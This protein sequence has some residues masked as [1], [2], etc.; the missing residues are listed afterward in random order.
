MQNIGALEGLIQEIYSRF[1]LENAKA[2]LNQ[3]VIH[4]CSHH[5]F[6]IN[7]SLLLFE[8]FQPFLVIDFKVIP[9]HCY[10]ALSFI[11]LAY[12]MSATGLINLSS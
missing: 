2:L 8:H 3:R 7:S 12:R 1:V 10:F 11:I 6:P 9:S 4:S 5:S